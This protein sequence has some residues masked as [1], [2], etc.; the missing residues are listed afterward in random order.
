MAATFVATAL[1][2]L[3][4]YLMGAWPI[5]GFLGLDVAALYWAFRMNYR[6]ARAYEDIRL[7]YF[8]LEFARVSSKGA[9]R[10]WLF[11]PAFVRFERIDHE[12][13]GPQRLSIVSRGRRWDVVVSS[14]LTRKR[15]SPTASRPHSPKRGAGQGMS[16]RIERS[17]FRGA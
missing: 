2:S 17:S 14:A 5:V 11:S 9:E 4:F 1:F 6:A 7:S 13:F 8:E 15:N 16:M 3:P 10:R 12:E